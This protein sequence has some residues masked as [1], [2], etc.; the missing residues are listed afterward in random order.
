MR[1]FWN[2][3]CLPSTEFLEIAKTYGVSQK[4][5]W[6]KHMYMGMANKADNAT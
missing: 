1:I 2:V 5:I 4:L 3:I 6:S